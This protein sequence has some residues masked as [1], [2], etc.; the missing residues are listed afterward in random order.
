MITVYKKCI[1][2]DYKSFVLVELEVE[3]GSFIQ[4]QYQYENVEH[5]K[6]LRKHYDEYVK[7]RNRDFPN[8]KVYTLEEYVEKYPWY[9]NKNKDQKCRGR[10]AK[11][12]KIHG[13]GSCAYSIYDQEFKYT[14]GAILEPKDAFEEGDFA[15]GSGIHFFLDKQN[16]IKYSNSTFIY[17]EEAGKKKDK[18]AE[19]NGWLLPF[20]KMIFVEDAIVD[21]E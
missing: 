8:E 15:C 7:L 14:V 13:G 5:E 11:V 3:E 2:E 19:A 12:V 9:K 20:P 18:R 16:A 10:K 17:L 1:S 6:D 21:K 4:S